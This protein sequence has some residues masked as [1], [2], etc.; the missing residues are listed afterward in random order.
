[1]LLA[2]VS[3][4]DRKP[5]DYFE[6]TDKFTLPILQVSA[7]GFPA[8]KDGRIR[9]VTARMTCDLGE[10]VQTGEVGPG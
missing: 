8:S 10:G 4:M 9:I 5:L 7:A 3:G 2:F 6:L 1:M